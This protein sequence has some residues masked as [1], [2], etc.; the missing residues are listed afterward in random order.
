MCV[1][2]SGEANYSSLLAG[3]LWSVWVRKTI[4]TEVRHTA[5]SKWGWAPSSTWTVHVFIMYIAVCKAFLPVP[6]ALANQKLHKR[7]GASH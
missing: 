2:A 4:K 5:H 6:L 7:R 1:G 3:L